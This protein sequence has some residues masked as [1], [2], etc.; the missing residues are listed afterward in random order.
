DKYELDG[1]DP[2]GFTGCAWSVMGIHDMGWKEREVFG[3]IRYMN[4]AG[5]KRKFDVQVY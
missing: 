3:K 5:C 2:N 4:Y 1:R